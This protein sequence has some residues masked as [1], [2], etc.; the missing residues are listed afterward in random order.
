MSKYY[1]NKAVFKSYCKL[2]PKDLTKWF[3]GL[4]ISRFGLLADHSLSTSRE[5]KPQLTARV[6]SCHLRTQISVSSLI[7]GQYAREL[8]SLSPSMLSMTKHRCCGISRKV[9]IGLLSAQCFIV[10]PTTLTFQS[11]LKLLFHTACTWTKLR[12]DRYLFTD[13]ASIQ[14][15]VIALRPASFVL[16]IS[17]KAVNYLNTKLYVSLGRRRRYN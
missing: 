11:R 6:E 14:K 12:R 15:K 17:L 10:D 9:P 7:A 2:W 1:K 3:Y 5:Q 8:T 4:K 16:S 13:V